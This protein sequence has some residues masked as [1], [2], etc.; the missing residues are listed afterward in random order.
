MR[1]SSKIL[2]SFLIISLAFFAV[3]ANAQVLNSDKKAEQKADGAAPVGDVS[4]AAIVSD[5][6]TD[7][8]QAVLID[9]N[10]D[11][12]LFEKSSEDKMFPSSMTK[13]ITMYLVFDQL[14]KAHVTMDSEITVSENAWKMGGSQMF[15]KVGDKVKVSDLIQ[16][17]TVQSGND[18]CVALAEGLAGSVDAFV[19]DMNTVAK[20]LGMLNTHFANPDGLPVDNHYTTAKD[21][22]VAAKRMI[23]DFP[24]YFH[25]YSQREFTYG[26]ITQ[27]N[28]NKLL[29]VVDLGVDGMKTGYTEMGGYGMIAT[30]VNNN[31]RLIAVVNGLET[32]K[33]RLKAA[34]LLLRYGYAN[35]KSIKLFEKFDAVGKIK[36]WNGIEDFVN[37]ESAKDVELLVNRKN[38]DTANYSAEI[39]Y[40]EPWVAPIKKGSH[41]ANLT[42]K[43]KS[44]KVLSQY[45]LYA[46]KDIAKAGIVKQMK[47]KIKHLLG[48]W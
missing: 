46:A 48:R 33:A 41:M 5:F 15:L 12:V 11:T 16:G 13:V 27:H 32:E 35:F 25:Y 18:A 24:E 34:E 42:I 8:K 7:A 10:S 30:G 28:R 40:K 19:D 37:V 22:S 44:G 3:S 47:Q 23:I 6:S 9:F 17:V 21:L 39:A 43:D 14:K 20:S 1:I 45:P 4:A 26:G 29:D 2:N 36:I 31:R 38:A